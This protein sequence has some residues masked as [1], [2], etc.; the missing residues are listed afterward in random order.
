VL[1]PLLHF[2][3]IGAAL[4]ALDRWLAPAPAPP[5]VVIGPERVEQLQTAFLV[6]AG[7]P[8]DPA[9]LRGLLRAEVDDEL[10]YRE[11]LRLGFD[12]DDPVVQRRLVQNMRFAGA[13]AERDAQALFEEALELGMDRSDP[14]V[15]RRLVQRMRLVI[16]ARALE[17]E[18][19]EEELR[20]YYEAHPERYRDPARVEIVQVF[21]DD[22]PP[23]EA[24]AALGVQR[25]SG[26]GP[27]DLGSLGDAFLHGP[28]Q[29]PQSERELAQRFGAAFARDVFALP[30]GEWSGPVGSSYGEHL[31][32]VRS[33]TPEV[34][35][36]F[37]EV[38]QEIRYAV[39]G[40]RRRRVLEEALAELRRGVEVEV[41]V[42]AP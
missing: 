26:A 23:G 36:P 33:H 38:R 7:R 4:F 30:V 22:E 37:D 1:R 24:V 14:V 42:A 15:R 17:P 3:W 35:R 41:A 28:Q 16:E 8:P 13:G 9:E 32:W 5:T 19:T 18:P 2:L 20:R 10:L 39:L 11:A 27:D 21:F 34:P 12:R 31:V 40:D 25:E 6:R 29:P